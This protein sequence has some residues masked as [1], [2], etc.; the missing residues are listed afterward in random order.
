MY[1][2]TAGCTAIVSA[3]EHSQL[4]KVRKDRGLRSCEIL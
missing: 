1:K 2:A 3:G 4:G